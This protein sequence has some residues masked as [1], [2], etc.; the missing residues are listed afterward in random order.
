ML[1]QAVFWSGGD[2]GDS[3]N[4]QTDGKNNG[5]KEKNVRRQRSKREKKDRW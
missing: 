3:K 2:G 1:L 5:G 4:E